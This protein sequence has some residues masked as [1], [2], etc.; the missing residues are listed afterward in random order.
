M[1]QKIRIMHIINNLEVG[2]AEKAL[3]LLTGEL[4]KRDDV[5][6]YVVSLEGHGELAGSLTKKVHLK[7]FKYHLFMPIISKFDPNFRLGLYLYALRIKPDIIHGHLFKGED[8][9]KV[10][11]ALT[12][13]PVVTTLHD[14]ETVPNWIGRFMNKYV[15]K[16]VAVSGMVADHLRKVY[17]FASDK[18]KVIPNAVDVGLFAD[19]K[20]K[21]DIEK[22]VFIY[23]GRLLG[24]KG[25]EDAIRGL[26]LLKAEYPGIKFLIYGKA[27]AESYN[28]YLKNL[29]YQNHWNFVKFMGKTNDVPAALKNGDIAILASQSEGFAISVLEAAA[30]SKPIIATKTGAIPDMVIDG[31]SGIFVEWHNPEQIYLAAKKLLDN[32]LVEKFGSVS[33]KLAADSYSIQHVAGMYYDLYQDVVCRK[34]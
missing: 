20:K 29:V 14:I 33:R 11:G 32:N 5:E 3:V 34:G 30:A 10:L 28:E 6:L 25:I 31:E 26:A 8:F 1:N 12:R 2:G 27:V 4:S 19:S 24:S 18:I 15:Q 17:G 13:R 23:I 9:A 7:E 22:P 16:A 21:F